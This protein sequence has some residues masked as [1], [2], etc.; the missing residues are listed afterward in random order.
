MNSMSELNW[1][2]DDIK[3]HDEV[4]WEYTENPLSIDPNGD[5]ME[6]GKDGYIRMNPKTHALIEATKEIRLSSLSQT[7]INEWKYRLDHLFDA[8][9]AFL[10]TD[11]QEGEIPIRIR[12]ND[13]SQHI[14]LKTSAQI[15]SKG[16]F[17]AHIREL[18]MKKQL[19]TL[20]LEP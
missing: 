17:D 8:G 10:F 6:A 5:W 14:G 20:D 18:R 9:V 13:L 2:L 11:D 12:F 4:C 7:N 15:W 16:R 19:G 3:N 1:D